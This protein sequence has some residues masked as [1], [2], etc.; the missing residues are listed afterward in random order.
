MPLSTS[1]ALLQAPCQ[2]GCA[3][4]DS[5]QVQYLTAEVH[6]LHKELLDTRT[7]L[8]GANQSNAKAVAEIKRLRED[9]DLKIRR[10]ELQIRSLELDVREA[11][12]KI[13]RLGQ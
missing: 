9:A 11:N 10:L 8:A 12:T 5:K 6:R 7:A 13:A 4:N 3:R 2:T 1:G